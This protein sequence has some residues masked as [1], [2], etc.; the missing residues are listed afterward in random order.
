VRLL[1]SLWTLRIVFGALC[2]GLTWSDNVFAAGEEGLFWEA[3]ATGRPTLILTPT[4]HILPDSGDDINDVL[5]SALMR[6][7]S[8]VIES[9]VMDPS[10]EENAAIQRR[11]MYTLSD[12]L[13][14][15]VGI[16]RLDDLRECANKAHI[17][18]FVFTRFKPWAATL[19]VMNR[20]KAPPAYE[21][22]EVRLTRGAIAAHRTF[23]TLVSSGQNADY[24]GAM[25]LGLQVT[26]LLETCKKLDHAVGNELVKDFEKDWRTGD[27][28][29]FAID[30]ER[31]LQPGDVPELQRASDIM[32]A[33]GSSIFLEA[34]VSERIQAL[35]GPILVAIGAAHLVGAASI[36]PMLEKQ[37][38]QVR[39]VSLNGYAIIPVVV[40]AGKATGARAPIATD[41]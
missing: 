30:I 25:P 4:L 38:Y 9:P 1:F 15:Y 24:L 32:Y 13:E 8:V 20:V 16:E 27:I 10:P 17:P 28:N 7:N 39:R 34:L 3:K 22:F 36:L 26:V 21:G 19:L 11:E 6:V 23:A 5:V 18:Y 12:S 2:I 14:N 33:K 37:G 40:Q 31:P 41:H 29:A 35:N